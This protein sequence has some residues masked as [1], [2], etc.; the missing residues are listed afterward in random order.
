MYN[1]GPVGAA[2]LSR[3]RAKQAEGFVRVA[4]GSPPY[5]RLFIFSFL[6]LFLCACAP[7]P[8]RQ[9][10][11][12][13]HVYSKVI[14]TAK[15][16][17]IG[18]LDAPAADLP[19]KVRAV[20]VPHGGEALP[21]AAAIFAA[22]ADRPPETIILI[23]PNHT[24]LG[25]K[26]ATT[27]AAF[28]NYDGLV[29]PQENI[30]QALEGRGLAGI[31]DALFEEEHS[32]G[33]IMPLLARHLP[34][35]KAVPLIFQKGVSFNAAKQAIDTACAI[36]GPDSLIVASIDFSHGL[37]S[38]EEQIRRAKILESIRA[39][40]AAVHLDL[41][42]T[43]LDAPVVLAALLQRCKENACAMELIEQANTS[44]LLGREVPAATGY[45]T[46][47]FYEP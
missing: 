16:A 34:G 46:I 14:N 41:D 15:F 29:L 20:I 45:M 10:T 17:P 12:S 24:S 33:I 5:K 47:A 21:M 13:A 25:P 28:S 32:V 4:V 26:I 7:E 36:A 11:E 40:D 42:S 43:Y 30:I 19:R 27:Y 8:A 31:E 2:T 38:R 9:P 3:L 6:L 44:E 35:V 1:A 22:L 37:S 23:G 18:D 39:Y